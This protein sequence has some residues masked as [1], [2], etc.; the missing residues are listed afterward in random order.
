VQQQEAAAFRPIFDFRFRFCWTFPRAH[1]TLFAAAG[2]G[3]NAVPAKKQNKCL[4]CGKPSLKAIC[5]ACADR[6]N[7]EAVHK[8]KKEHKGTH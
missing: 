7:S 2:L 4:L 1:P 8:K 6:V 3:G 5:N